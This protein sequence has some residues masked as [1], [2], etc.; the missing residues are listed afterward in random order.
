M[1]AGGGVKDHSVRRQLPGVLAPLEELALDL[2]WT[3]SHS[4]DDLWRQ[5]DADAWERS[6][7]PL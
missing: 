3:W 2:R 6:E 7:N 5:L 1:G 4:A